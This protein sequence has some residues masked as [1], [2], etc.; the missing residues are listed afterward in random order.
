M[1]RRLVII[2]GILVILGLHFLP[3][4]PF[5]PRME[6]RIPEGCTG[7]LTSDLLECKYTF[8]D[9]TWIIKRGY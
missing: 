8:P 3:E 7:S 5:V 2:A 1:I 6:S 9:G 4:Q